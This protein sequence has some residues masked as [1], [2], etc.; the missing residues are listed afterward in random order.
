MEEHLTEHGFIAI[1]NDP[2]VGYDKKFYK[3]KA[4]DLDVDVKHIMGCVWAWKENKDQLNDIMTGKYQAKM[5]RIK[6]LS[7]RGM[8]KDINN[9]P[10]DEE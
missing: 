10:K 3:G 8:F 9:C 1:N 4:E 5:D 7:E 2:N 6:K